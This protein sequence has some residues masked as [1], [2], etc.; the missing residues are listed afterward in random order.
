MKLNLATENWRETILN[1]IDRAEDQAGVDSSATD[2]AD[3]DNFADEVAGDV[4][5][6][7]TDSG[8]DYERSYSQSVGS[9]VI[10]QRGTDQEQEAFGAALG[11]AKEA[12]FPKIVAK[13]KE[14]AVAIAERR[15]EEAAK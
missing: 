8:F 2:A 7:L 13:A 12:V 11:K 15:A 6:D 5:R 1:L 10:V 3:Y 9:F 4:L 14:F